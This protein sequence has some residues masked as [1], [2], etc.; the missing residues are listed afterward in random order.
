MSRN[1]LV[2]TGSPRKGGNTSIMADTF[3]EGARGAGHK[4]TRVDAGLAN[5]NGCIGC[6]YCF[7]HQGECFQKDDMQDIYP[8]IR[9]CDTLVYAT[10]I[11]YF[12]FPAQFKAF[13]DRMFCGLANPFG[14]KNT[15]LL[16]VFEDKD[17]TISK[18]IIDTY[19][20]GVAY[21]K[22]N[23]LGVVA[24]NNCF[25]KGAI[26]SDPRLEEVRTFGASL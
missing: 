21:S 20:I 11:Y 9:A 3:I 25:E 5:I 12:T 6:Q 22:W 7:A 23:D 19:R 2:V 15:A 24:I 14:T 10:P 13:M 17:E 1:I 4:V 16:T 26:E 8:L 18:H